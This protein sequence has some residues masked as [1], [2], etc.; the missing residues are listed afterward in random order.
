MGNIGIA[1]GYANIL[2]Q[3]HSWNHLSIA[4]MAERPQVTKGCIK[5]LQKYKCC[6]ITIQTQTTKHVIGLRGRAAT[7]DMLQNV[8]VNSHVHSRRL[9]FGTTRTANEKM[10][11][12]PAVTK[13]DLVTSCTAAP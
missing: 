1:M 5:G 6:G 13:G 3:W 10:N 8:I 7:F 4:I 9:L 11:P 2:C 12:R